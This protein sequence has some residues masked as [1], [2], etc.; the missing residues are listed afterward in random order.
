MK[1]LILLSVVLVTLG[2]CTKIEE[3]PAKC[4]N[5]PPTPSISSGSYTRNLGDTISFIIS[6]HSSGTAYTWHSPD[7]STQT[8]TSGVYSFFVGSTDIEGENWVEATT[9]NAFCA[10]DRAKFNVTVNNFFPTCTIA[11]DDVKI[12][13]SSTFYTYSP[14]TYSYSD[15]YRASWYTQSG[16]NFAIDFGN[17]TAGNNTT[18][19]RAADEGSYDLDDNEC[20]IDFYFNSYSYEA[21]EGT[22]YVRYES[23]TGDYHVQFCDV[24][25]KRSN[26]TL[27]YN[28]MGSLYF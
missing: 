28:S 4:S 3:V 14:S 20:R 18:V 23:A 11:D 2:A 13:G 17:F 19:Y 26:G 27:Y 16:Y 1:K 24:T 15:V 25:F 5:Q 22:V 9:S 21:T 7:G 8:S 10:S 6:N 12:G